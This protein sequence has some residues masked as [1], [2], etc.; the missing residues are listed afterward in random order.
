VNLL[1]AIKRTNNPAVLTNDD[2]VGARR[3]RLRRE[4]RAVPSGPLANGEGPG[5][6]QVD[7]VGGVTVHGNG[8]RLTE[9]DII[10]RQNAEAVTGHVHDQPDVRGALDLPEDVRAITQ[11]ER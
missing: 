3:L 11:V 9:V 7:E 10:C 5:R 8:E 4:H 1:V 6:L 2:A